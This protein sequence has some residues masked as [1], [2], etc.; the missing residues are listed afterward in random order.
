[1]AQNSN[2][3]SI[4]A[5]SFFRPVLVTGLIEALLTQ[6]FQKR[7][8]RAWNPKSPD[9]R[10]EKPALLFVLAGRSL[11]RWAGV[12]GNGKRPVVGI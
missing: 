4:W 5:Y 1:M 12:G 10:G 2:L 3:G 9:L 6:Y 8:I 7:A 11:F